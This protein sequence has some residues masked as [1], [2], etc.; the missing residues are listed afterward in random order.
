M[1][2]LCPSPPTA[3]ARSPQSPSWP[4]T[5]RSGVEGRLRRGGKEGECT[6]EYVKERT[7]RGEKQ[8]L[9]Q[10]ETMASDCAEVLVA[11]KQLNASV[12]S[13]QVLQPLSL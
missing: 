1:A 13:L 9:K 3:T 12:A 8:D 4:H 2:A 5:E 10:A 11:S 7:L 6:N